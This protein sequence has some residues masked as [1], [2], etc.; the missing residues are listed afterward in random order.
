MKIGWMI[1]DDIPFGNDNRM[2]LARIE[3]PAAGY[4]LYFMRLGIQEKE[5]RTDD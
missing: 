2:L 3:G 5:D 4:A 1:E